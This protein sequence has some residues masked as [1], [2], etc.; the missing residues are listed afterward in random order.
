MGYWVWGMGDGRWE[1]GCTVREIKEL[2]DQ[3]VSKP[4]QK[5]G[6]ETD[7]HAE[8]SQVNQNQNGRNMAGMRI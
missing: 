5:A 6:S 8:C 2:R 7:M 3:N 1:M 4:A